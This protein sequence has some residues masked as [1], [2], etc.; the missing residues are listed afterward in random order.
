MGGVGRVSKICVGTAKRK[1]KENSIDG[2]RGISK[3]INFYMVD[4]ISLW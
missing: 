3:D 4:P 1:K 2:G